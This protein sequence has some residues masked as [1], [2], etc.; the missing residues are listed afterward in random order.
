[1]HL[2]YDVAI[3]GGGFSGLATLANIVRGAQ[4]PLSIAVISRDKQGVFGP[5][6]STPREEHLLNVYARNMG[7]YAD[8]AR[9]FLEWVRAQG[10][11]AEGGDFLPRRLYARYLQAVLDETRELAKEK[12]IALDWFAGKVEDVEDHD[13]FLAMRSGEDLIPAYNIVLAIGN[14]LKGTEDAGGV[15]LVGN[16]WSYNFSTLSGGRQK[17]ALIGSGL[18]AADTI[19]SLLDCGWQGKMTCYSGSGLLPQPHLDGYDHALRQKFSGEQFISH[20]LSQI[21]QALRTEIKKGETDWRYVV[22]GLRPLTQDIWRSLTTTD[23]KR[24][25]GKYFMLWNTHRHRYAPPIGQRINEAIKSGRLEMV[26]ARVTGTQESESGVT[27][28]FANNPPTGFDLVFKCTGVNYNIDSNPLLKHL[29]GKGM[30]KPMPGN[31]G[32]RASDSYA[33]YRKKP[34]IMYALGAPLF[35]QLFETTAVPELREQA[36]TVAKAILQTVSAVQQS[37]AAVRGG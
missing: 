15:K 14:S 10:L 23:K 29:A 5:A 4:A 1:M 19:I 36:S 35:G 12:R 24:L 7:L 33:V 32:L 20:S 3:I 17:I 25:T 30:L 9:H 18:T 34:A 26:K 6:Y 27:L 2:A 28:E 8:N 22:D 13:D 31:D 11:T 21:M 16:P 37:L